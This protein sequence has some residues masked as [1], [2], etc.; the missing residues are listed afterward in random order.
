M[1]GSYEYKADL[2][3]K[4]N[5]MTIDFEMIWVWFGLSVRTWAEVKTGFLEKSGRLNLQEVQGSLASAFNKIRQSHA[6]ST[7]GKGNVCGNFLPRNLFDCL[8]VFQIWEYLHC[9]PH[10]RTNMLGPN[11]AS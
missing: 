11:M 9:L 4:K 7:A 3:Y 10:I 1:L 6:I 8:D 2:E 5:C